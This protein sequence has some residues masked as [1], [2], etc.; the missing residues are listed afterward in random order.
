MTSDLFS[1][2]GIDAAT[3]A[4]PLDQDDFSAAET[5]AARY[6]LGQTFDPANREANDYYPTHPVATLALLGVEQFAGAI[7]EPACGEGYISK[8]LADAGHYVISTDLV[9]YGFGCAGVDFLTWPHGNDRAPNIVTNPPFKLAF[10]FIGKALALTHGQG[11]KVA[12]FLRLAFLAGQKRGRWFGTTPLARI[13]VMSR[14]V[15]IQRGRIATA[16]DNTGPLDF[17]WAVWDWSHPIGQPPTVHFV[18]WKEHAQ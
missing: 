10:Q 2:A 3:L 8:V 5:A 13:Y 6:A 18:D 9:D 1:T 17:I 14:R 11:G 15:P 7:W 12:M 16:D 4:A